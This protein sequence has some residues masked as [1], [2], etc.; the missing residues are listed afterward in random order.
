MDDCVKRGLR[1]TTLITYKRQVVFFEKNFKAINKD[2]QQIKANDVYDL[3]NSKISF[4]KNLSKR[5]TVEFLKYIF[6][7]AKKTI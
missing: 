2:I 5:K 6:T 3:I 4:R 1:P 7:Y